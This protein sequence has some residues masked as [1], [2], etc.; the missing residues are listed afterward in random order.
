MS[1]GGL[2]RTS[3][4]GSSEGAYA[5]ILEK[6]GTSMMVLERSDTSARSES[7]FDSATL[8]GLLRWRASHQPDRRAYSF[9]TDGET[10]VVALTYAQLDQR[11]RAIAA[12]L[13]SQDAS[14]T[15]V[16][17]L[18]P[19]GLDYIAAFFGCL[20]AGVIAV[21]A[22]P[23]R[24][25]RSLARIQAI[26]ADAQATSALT[27][28]ALLPR[29]AATFDHTPDLQAL[30]WLA[31][32]SFSA[33]SAGELAQ[34]DAD[35]SDSLAD[36]WQEPALSGETLA[37]L[38][39]TSGSTG[40]P[41]GVMVSHGNLLGNLEVIRRCYEHTSDSVGVIW[42]PP[43]HD[44]GLI[45]GI[46]QPLY[47]GFPVVL[48]SPTAFL[49]RPIRWLRA[50]SRYHATTSGGPNFA[51]DLC[52]RKITPEQRAT[53]DLSSW[54]VAFNGA[55]PIR[56]ETLDRFTA[57]FAPCGFRRTAFYPCYGLAE[58]TL[59]VSGGRKADPPVLYTV[60]RTAL[61][62]Q[63]AQPAAADEE[64]AL[65]LVSNGWTRAGQR[66]VIANPDSCQ[67]CAPGEVGEIWLAGPC[68]AKGYWNRPE[69]T[70]ETFQAYLTTGEGPFLRT[71]DLGFVHAGEL[72]I[73]GRAKDVIVIRGMNHY[74]QDIELTVEKSHPSLRPG[75][76][77]AFAV[78]VAGAERLVVAQ[79]VAGHHRPDVAA[80][81][82]AVRQAVFE[83][84][85]LQVYTVVLIE[86]GS[87][88]K[89]SSGKIQR[90]ACRADF[91]AGTLHVVGSSVIKL[92]PESERPARPA[93]SAERKFAYSRLTSPC[94]HHTTDPDSEK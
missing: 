73:T 68:I 22:Y 54:D 2:F 89:T 44:M 29:I 3:T 41:K 79:E 25:N 36:A 34:R 52:A 67:A 85:E 31:T 70:V 35:T 23:P 78:E 10:T 80:V 9:L 62:Q 83:Q 14:G 72:Y 60:Q 82:E 59:L 92:L 46:L 13:Q 18:Y 28:S 16:L 64:D 37:F 90:H 74:P 63:R 27:T 6:R 76:G 56:P 8:V 21:P 84:H 24:L 32:D 5:T 57:A 93:Q 20:Y 94:R 11:A 77:A 58:A 38:Q 12:W 55:E 71:G 86:Q 40:T 91:L 4:E 15:R 19:P 51:Y 42:L 47:A 75:C 7:P 43:Y 87:I 65:T 66:L 49:Q 26:V 88:P 50:V 69:E 39:Y 45:G 33:G 1:A 81:A 30:R 53:L 61:E 17:L 48:M